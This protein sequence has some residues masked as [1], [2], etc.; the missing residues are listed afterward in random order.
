MQA[1][2]QAWPLVLLTS[3]DQTVLSCRAEHLE[4]P[5]HACCQFSVSADSD[6]WCISSDSTTLI[7]VTEKELKEVLAHQNL[8]A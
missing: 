7:G 4:A 5:I 2:I 3:D 6:F 8:P 1:G